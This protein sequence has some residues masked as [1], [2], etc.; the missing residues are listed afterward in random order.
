MLWNC[1]NCGCQQ[2][3]ASVTYCPQCGRDREDVAKNTVEGG[4][5]DQGDPH[6]DVEVEL[7]TAEAGAPASEP[8]SPADESGQ[9]EAVEVQGEVTVTRKG[10]VK[11]KE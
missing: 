4:Y 6:E 1:G 3:A 10:A 5:S 2:I 7:P 8:E 11:P 9:D